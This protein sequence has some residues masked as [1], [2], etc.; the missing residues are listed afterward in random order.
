M[1]E[2]L[3]VRIASND[4]ASEILNSA[5]VGCFISGPLVPSAN[6]GCTMKHHT[7]ASNGS[8]KTGGI[9][10]IANNHLAS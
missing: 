3:Q 5:Y 6:I 2:S 10:Q 9:A 4:S 1:N 8:I 7:Y